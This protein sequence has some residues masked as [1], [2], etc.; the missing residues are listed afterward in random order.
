VASF[1][2]GGYEMMQFFEVLTEDKPG[3][4]ARVV[5]IVGARGENI[6]RI[7]AAP[8]AAGFSR[9]V[10]LVEMPVAQAEFVR[11][12][13]LKIVTVLSAGVQPAASTS[14]SITLDDNEQTAR[15]EPVVAPGRLACG[16]PGSAISDG[17]AHGL[18]ARAAGI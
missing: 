3:V 15:K 17:G 8:V 1:V 13:L 11:R 10:V 6:A 2:F 16:M 12:K 4:L 14:G 9:I 7:A 5:G 18:P